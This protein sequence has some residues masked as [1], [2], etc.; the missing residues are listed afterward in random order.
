MQ[1]TSLKNIN[2]YTFKTKPWSHQLMAL[3]YLMSQKTG[4]L[5]TD[6]GTGKSKVIIDLI[7]NKGFKSVLIVCTKKGCD[8]WVKQFAIH[9]DLENKNIVNLTNYSTTDKTSLL[10]K[11]TKFYSK[12]PDKTMHSIFICNYES[13]WREPF[14]SKLLKT[15]IDCVI[16]DESHRIKTPGSKC[17]KFLSKLGKNIENKYLVTGTPLAENPTDIYA[18]YRFLNPAIFGTSLTAF[19]ER[20]EKLDAA[21]TAQVGYR[22]LDSKE[23]YI[24]LDELKE[25]MFSCA[26]MAKSEVKL[27]KRL[28]IIQTF[29]LSKKAIQAYKDIT[30]TGVIEIENEGQL[31]VE[32]ALSLSLRQQQIT[33]GFIPLLDDDFQPCG[34]KIIDTGKIEAFQELIEGLPKNEPVVVFAKF[35]RDL[36]SIREICLYRGW[37]YSEISGSCDEEAEWQAGK[38]QILGVQYASGS[39]SITLT[40]AH[41][42]IYYSLTYS[43]SQYKQSK[44]RIHRPGQEQNCIYYYLIAELDRGKTI[45]RTIVEALQKKNDII[46][47]IVNDIKNIGKNN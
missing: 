11:M 3:N 21:R 31:T 32:N 46:S 36:T 27:P 39:E 35:R 24:N 12:N 18:Q 20:Y 17:S 43:L 29:K 2:N 25:K 37:K 26:F 40:R 8:N 45:D 44:K 14:A 4:A 23:P 9:S 33:S 34:E 41:Y 22:V 47:S 15:P 1:A 16:C 38:T 30:K 42:C 6:M 13:V 5:Y 19:R 28:N 10:T 7:V